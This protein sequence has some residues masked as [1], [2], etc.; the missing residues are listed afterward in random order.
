MRAPFLWGKLVGSV[1]E[2]IHR[3]IQTDRYTNREAD[4]D[5]H[6]HRGLKKE[7]KKGGEGSEKEGLGEIQ[8]RERK[9][10]SCKKRES[11]SENGEKS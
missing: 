6:M 10:G 1:R 11:S 7:R 5:T 3:H 2:Q 4:T 9:N 8:Q